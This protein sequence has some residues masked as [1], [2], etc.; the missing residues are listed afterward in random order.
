MA[1]KTKTVTQ[2]NSEANR[3]KRLARTLKLQPTNEQVIRAMKTSRMRRKTPTN[4]VWSHY[5]KHMAQVFKQFSGKFDKGIMSSNPKT[6]QEAMLA[7]RADSTYTPMPVPKRQFSIGERAHC[8]G[9]P[10]KWNS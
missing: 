7:S 3:M 4:Q 5:W 1:T 10:I 6:A 9:V 8:K 2:D